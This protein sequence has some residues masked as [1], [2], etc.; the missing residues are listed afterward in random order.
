MPRNGEADPEDYGPPKQRSQR[1]AYQGRNLGRRHAMKIS[2]RELAP[3][4]LLLMLVPGCTTYAQMLASNTAMGVV[5]A[6]TGT[7]TELY[8][9]F[10]TQVINTIF[11]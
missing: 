5:D 9:K 3:L 11:Q 2:I 7:F 6:V 4:C 1:A 8:V 10:L